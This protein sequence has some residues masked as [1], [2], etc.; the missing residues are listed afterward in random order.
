MGRVG[1]GGMNDGGAGRRRGR[2]AKEPTSGGAREQSGMRPY[3]YGRTCPAS[4]HHWLRQTPQS[5]RL[6][7]QPQ[8]TQAGESHTRPPPLATQGGI[9]AG[10]RAGG[11][12]GSVASRVAPVTP[13]EWVAAVAA[14]GGAGGLGPCSTCSMCPC[15]TCSMCPCSTCSMCPCST[16]SMC[17]CSTC[18]MCPCSTRTG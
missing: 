6:R 15:S 7:R 16:C 9:G 2:G 5:P 10:H 3:L 8:R 1:G 11:C 18:S 13:P 17:P 4:T 14:L 12:A